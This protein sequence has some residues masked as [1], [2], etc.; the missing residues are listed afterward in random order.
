MTPTQTKIAAQLAE[1]IAY[2]ESKGYP[3]TEGQRRYL[4]KLV[5]NREL[6]SIRII[7]FGSWGIQVQY[8]YPYRGAIAKTRITKVL[9]P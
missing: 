3:V 5:R 2:I 9:H 1:R 6:V 7:R 4:R 8:Q